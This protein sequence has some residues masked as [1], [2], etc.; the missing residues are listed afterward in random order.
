MNSQLY[1]LPRLVPKLK[2]QAV[3]RLFLMNGTAV[4]HRGQQMTH[5]LHPM[6]EVK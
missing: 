6:K 2:P 3:M 5:Q 1:R 4:E